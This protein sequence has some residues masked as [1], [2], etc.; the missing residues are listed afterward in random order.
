[1]E[2]IS[3]GFFP[4]DMFVNTVSMQ[5]RYKYSVALYGMYNVPLFTEKNIF[6]YVLFYCI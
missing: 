3:L 1:M 4:E 5:I 6:P 2:F